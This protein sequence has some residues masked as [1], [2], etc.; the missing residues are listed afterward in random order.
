MDE[1]QQP[2]VAPAPSLG[3]LPGAA[4]VRHGRPMNAAGRSATT[5]DV[6]MR[7]IRKCWTSRLG[8]SA[9]ECSATPA[10]RDKVGGWP[11]AGPRR[12]PLVP[13]TSTAAA[14]EL[15]SS[16]VRDR[17]GR[18]RRAL[19]PRLTE[20]SRR[21]ALQGRCRKIRVAVRATARTALRPRPPA[22][23]PTVRRTRRCPA[24][25]KL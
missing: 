14:L 9:S 24:R 19:T 22:E 12:Y 7:R 2:S 16:G 5:A 20:S 4:R 25:A 1:R 3:G 6:P 18:L 10:R 13:R 17:R 23:D 8:M 21:R 15:A 11:P